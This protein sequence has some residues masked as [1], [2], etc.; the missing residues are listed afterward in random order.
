PLDDSSRRRPESTLPDSG[1]FHLRADL[2]I[3]PVGVFGSSATSD[4]LRGNLNRASRPSQ[5][6]LSSSKVGSS[7][8]ETGTTQTATCCPHSGSDTP[9][10]AHSATLCWSSRTDSTS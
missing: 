1:L 7:S 4:S 9:A 10:A 6:S 3:L 5:W 2:R 8:K